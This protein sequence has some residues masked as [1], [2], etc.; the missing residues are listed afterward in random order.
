[1][2][3]SF[4]FG[5]NWQHFL[6]VL[7]SERIREAENSLK[8]MLEIESLKGRRFLDIGSG[9]G[10]FSLAAH[11]LGAEVVSFDYDP[12]SVACTEEVKRRYASES[13]NWRIE[14]GSAL[15]KEYV[16]ALGQ[17]DIVYSW[18]VLHHTGDMWRAIE[19]SVMAVAPGGHLFIAIYNNQGRASRIWTHIKQ[20]YNASPRPV[21]WL[22]V[23]AA[24]AYFE[25]R[26]LA[27][28]LAAPRRYKRAQPKRGRGM[29][30]WYDLVDW[31]GGYPFEV[32]KP[33]EIFDFYRKHGF[34]LCRLRTCAGG[35]GCNEFVFK[36]S[37]QK[38]G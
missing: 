24:G 22:L 23:L 1:M 8:E 20:L 13:I 25:L 16:Q 35:I 17:F 2:S 7:D 12:A 10:L 28:R 33:D 21:K 29:A 36:R 6:S 5:A 38:D 19:N 14:R 9:S 32:A 30:K 4:S 11:R 26:S 15:D 18:G 3:K 37:L 31:V 27:A 34:T